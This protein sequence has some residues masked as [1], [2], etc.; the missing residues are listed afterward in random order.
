MEVKPEDL[1]YST[2]KIAEMSTWPYYQGFTADTCGSCKKTAN[3]LAGDPGWFCACGH[4]NV[5]PF[6]GSRIP[7]DSPDLGPSQEII[8]EG[9]R[10]G[11]ENVK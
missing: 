11:K 10:L 7:Y 1:M 6:H 5:L 2:E 3:V 4:F 8:K 9:H